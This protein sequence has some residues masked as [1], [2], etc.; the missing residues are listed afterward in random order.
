MSGVVDRLGGKVTGFSPGEEVFGATNASFV[1]GYAEFAAC[2]ANMIAKK[3]RTLCDV[4][5]ASVPVVAVTAWQMLFDHAHAKEGQTV[6][7][8]GA[9]GNV[10]AYA[11]QLARR[12]RL[13]V[14]ASVRGRDDVDYVRT[15][16]A[17]EVMQCADVV[18]DTVG[19]PMQD[20]LFSLTKPGGV[21][22][23]VV[24]PPNVQRALRRPEAT[25]RCSGTVRSLLRHFPSCGFEAGTY[26]RAT[27]FAPT[28]N[29]TRSRQRIQSVS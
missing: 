9:A 14:I 24:S 1:G 5:A 2:S 8:Q 22:V 12:S 18:I 20:R 27:D 28:M 23:S 11:V 10:C 7:V 29:S 13:R 6:L 26:R 19:G 3:P 4:E 25:A 16:G 21:V 17:D 15:L